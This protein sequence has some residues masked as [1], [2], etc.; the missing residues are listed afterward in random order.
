MT[1]PDTASGEAVWPE[2]QLQ[3]LSRLIQLEGEIR[4][5]SGA[6]AIDFI[7]VNDSHR[8]VGYD[9]ALVWRSRTGAVTAV[10]GG[11]IVDRHAPQIV[12]FGRLARHFAA[13]KAK[14]QD[15]DK[16]ELPAA[17][18][19]GFVKWISA[20][21]LWV[22]LTAP[23]ESNEGGLIFLRAEP[24]ND[25]EKRILSRIG[26]AIG[27][28]IAAIEGPRRRVWFGT[29]PLTIAALLIAIAAGAIPVPLTVLAEAKVAPVDPTIIAAPIDGVIKG[30]PVEPNEAVPAGR[31]LV[32]FDSTELSAAHD[33]A[34]KHVAVLTADWLRLEEKSFKD[35]KAREDV[36]GARSRLAEGEAELGFTVDKLHRAEIRA[37]SAGV[38][39]IE[40]RNQWLGRPVK[41]GERIMSLADPRDVRLEIQIP[42]EDALVATAGAPIEFFLAI[43]PAKPVHARLTRMSYEA[44]LLPNQTSAFA[45][46]ADFVDDSG[47]P[48]LGLTGTAK[49]YGEHVPLFY[50]IF[51]RPLAH[52]RRLL[53]F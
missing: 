27:Q 37:T 29:R 40:D 4:A 49:I 18:H 42:V 2:R 12:W 25:S 32:E 53:G 44:R 15:I 39:M 24:F 13:G 5:A 30:I 11:L 23:R 45:G 46:E 8:L 33:V 36:S 19:P 17:L 20:W 48:R 1:Q 6:R 47:L 50:A 28:A 52:M 26:G 9:H 7:A 41:I 16:A 22:P 14:P 10:S 21:A 38:V 31:P 43:A 3:G 51:R 34:A 35:E